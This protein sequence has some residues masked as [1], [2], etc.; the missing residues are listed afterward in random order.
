MPENT[1]VLTRKQYMSA[2]SVRHETYYAQFVTEETLR[3]VQNAFGIE[4]LSEALTADR[5]LNT[6]PLSQW[7]NIS[8]REINPPRFKNVAAQPNRFVATVPFNREVAAAAGEAVT[9]STLICI[10]KSAARTLVLQHARRA[11]LIDA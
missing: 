3:T 4:R 10:V 2:S 11:E 5:H 7:D 8:F 1:P 9:R 6:I